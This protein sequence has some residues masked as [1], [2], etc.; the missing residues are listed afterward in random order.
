[1]GGP[2]WLRMARKAVGLESLPEH[3]ALETLL[4]QEGKEPHNDFRIAAWVVPPIVVAVLGIPAFLI[5]SDVGGPAWL[6]TLPAVLVPAGLWS[7]FF[8]LDRRI[9][10]PLRRIRSLSDAIRKR[11]LRIGSLVGDQ[12]V[13]SPRVAEALDVAAAIYLRNRPPSTVRGRTNQSGPGERTREALEA[14]MLRLLELL[15]PEA[16]IEQ[17]A[18]F[19]QG[20][21]IPLIAEMEA[22]AHSL[23]RLSNGL[24]AL[25]AAHDPLANL[26]D[27]R[28]ELQSIEAA[29]NE[30]DIRPQ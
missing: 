17:E 29:V 16:P 18:V 13:V 3:R 7:L 23:D 27:A 14:A 8:Y 25:E 2:T 15:S 5:A 6:L 11:Y 20:W 1:M 21:A 26:R 9:P 10:E 30:L 22:A 19:D 28:I 12:P 24:S 4:V